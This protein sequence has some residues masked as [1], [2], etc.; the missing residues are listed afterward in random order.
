MAQK[1]Y[2]PSPEKPWYCFD[3]DDKTYYET[4]ELAIEAAKDAIVGHLDEFWSEE[5]GRVQVGKV[6]Q[7][8]IQ[9]DKRE[10]PDDIDEE[11]C[12]QNGE[13]WGDCD[14]KCNYITM[15]LI[16]DSESGQGENCG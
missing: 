15:P 11:G 12:D 10:R 14:Y 13:Y 2:N 9:T 4:E 3:G 7:V 6:T 16:T 1:T 8:T 5:V